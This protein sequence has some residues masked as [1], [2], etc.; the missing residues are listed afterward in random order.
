MSQAPDGDIWL[1]TG[2]ECLVISV[3]VTRGVRL[4]KRG[5]VEMRKCGD[6]W[7]SLKFTFLFLPSPF[8]AT[9]I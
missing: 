6:G 7:V 1:Y 8:F 5:N 3:P 9:E 2:T 4:R